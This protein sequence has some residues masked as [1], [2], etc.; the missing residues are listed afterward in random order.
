MIWAAKK[1]DAENQILKQAL[2]IVTQQQ[3]PNVF[4]QPP[5]GSYGN[6]YNMPNMQYMPKY[7]VRNRTWRY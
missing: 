5:H 7:D 1:K 6:A 4:Y 2:T 3:Q